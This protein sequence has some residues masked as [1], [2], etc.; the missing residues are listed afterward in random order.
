MMEGGSTDEV[1]A[2]GAVSGIKN[3]YGMLYFVIFIL[4]DTS[5]ANN[6]NV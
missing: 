4:M 2:F 6:F 3:I 5:L 1:E